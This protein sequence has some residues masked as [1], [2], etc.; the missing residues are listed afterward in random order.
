[1]QAWAVPSHQPAR[2]V[3]KI[4]QV[5]AL[6]AT[7]QPLVVSEPSLPQLHGVGF[8]PHLRQAVRP[9][10]RELMAVVTPGQQ[11]EPPTSETQGQEV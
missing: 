2:Q 3:L 10:A 1:M 5:Q 6:P 8:A 11:A 4:K 7:Q 9:T